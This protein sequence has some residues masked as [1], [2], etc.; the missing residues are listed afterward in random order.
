MYLKALEIQGF[1]SFPEKVTLSFE[2]NLTAI[3]GPNGSGKS[4][5]S[6]AI[7]WVMGEQRTRTLRGSKMEDVI[8]GGSELRNQLSFAQV[9]LIIDNSDKIFDID[10]SDL[11]ITRRYY[12]SGESEYYINKKLVRLKDIYEILMDTG[13]GRD[14]YSIIGQGRV[15]EII[16]SKGTERR[17][18]FEEAA[19][20][21]KFRHR[22]EEA[23]R[24]LEKTDADIIR[25]GDKIAELEI[26]VEP[27]HKQAETAKKYLIL[28]DELRGLEISLWMDSLD[29]LAARN[30]EISSEYSDAKQRLEL[31]K[32]DLELLY[33]NSSEYSGE[34]RQK[35]IDCE[36]I[37]TDI[38][39]VEALISESES[40]VAVMRANREGALE[41][42]SRIENELADIRIRTSAISEQIDQKR[43]RILQIDKL[44]EALTE[45][46][47]AVRLQNDE[48]SAGTNEAE[49]RITQLLSMAASYE[50]SLKAAQARIAAIDASQDDLAIRYKT[51][52]EALTDSTNK[53]KAAYE[54]QK[55]KKASLDNARD[56]HLSLNNVIRGLD[57]KSESKKIKADKLNHEL[58]ELRLKRSAARSQ[59]SLLNEMEKEYEGFSKA[60]QMVMR[61]SQRGSLKNIDGTVADL[62]STNDEHTVAIET[63]LG[64]SLQ[65]IVVA[66][67]EDGKAAI[68]MLRRNDAGRATFLPLTAIKGNVIQEK[69]IKSEPG[70]HDVAYNLVRFDSK[71]DGIFAN[72]L[73]RTIVSE[74]LDS[75]I[76]LSRKHSGKYRIVTLDGQIINAG[77]SMTG[78]S[79]ARNVG[80]LSRANEL[81]RLIDEE[82]N[83]EK[84]QSELERKHSDAERE[85][86][87]ILFEAETA[88]TESRLISDEILRLETEIKQGEMLIKTMEDNRKSLEDSVV[89]TKKMLDIG[90]EERTSCEQQSL[91]YERL[92]AEKRSDAEKEAEGQRGLRS[93]LDDISAKMSDMISERSSLLAEKEATERAIEEFQN[94]INGFNVDFD[95]KA[96]HLA[97]LRTQIGTIDDEIRIAA[98]K[99]NEYR[100]SASLNREK[101]SA[102][103]SEKLEYESKRER[104]E[105]SAQ[106]KSRTLMEMERSIS[107]LEQKKLSAELEERQI[108]DKLWDNYE[109]S[110]T[111]AQKLRRE[112]ENSAKAQKRLA[113]IR[114]EMSGLGTPNLG[115]IEEFERVNSRYLFLTDQR[116]DITRSKKELESIIRDITSQMKEIFSREFTAINTAFAETFSELFGGGKAE[117]VLE[118]EDDVLGSNIEIRAQPPGKT[119]KTLTLL[120]GGERAFV[121]I[122]LYFAI[123]RVRPAPFCVLDE[124]DTALDEKNVERFA[125]YLRS[126]SD[127]TQFLV[128]THRRGTMEEADVLFGVTMQGGISKI[129]SIDL[130]EALKKL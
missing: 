71:Y 4:N 86:S 101:L 30:L 27:L 45:R 119:T 111:A 107:L 33:L 127:K 66:R 73:G 49:Q 92:A 51:Q 78:G 29:R 106:E 52:L 18:I 88:K 113:E 2:K 48:T 54:D 122:A 59:I 99:L 102:A 121:A 89:N 15:E 38:A 50:S 46:I 44:N 28:R 90:K 76:L 42:I 98:E 116:D 62:I 70:V 1:K 47:A 58:A 115:A 105:K 69:A 6:D 81:K 93:L 13:L 68:N 110:R 5:I 94:L 39:A 125:S 96:T 128:I 11:M 91:E 14:G 120:S 36:N 65:S 117:L 126:I 87:A 124:I 61:E 37:R 84:S 77:G 56:T 123:L 109:L 16:S 112:N 20:I 60:V 41:S 129:L 26:Q 32:S 82:A 97:A 3:V 80:I 35:D 43:S 104:C 17:E 130:E 74:D 19:G 22:K 75:A 100:I 63:A 9:T 64:N 25:V 57:L 31:L 118:D 10:T 67:E 114:R 72:L 7:T 95:D 108:I 24:K 103:L 53:L 83:Y 8:F 79:S 23:E 34:I 21:S 40:A 55:S 85:L 12:R